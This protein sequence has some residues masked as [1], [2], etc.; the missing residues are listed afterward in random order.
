MLKLG[1]DEP[2]TRSTVSAGSSTDSAKLVL[3]EFEELLGEVERFHLYPNQIV[4]NFRTRLSVSLSRNPQNL[5]LIGS[6]RPGDRVALIRVESDQY[7]LR[8][9]R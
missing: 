6:L 2:V 5:H 7:L 1:A 9:L 8:E 4:L 3:L